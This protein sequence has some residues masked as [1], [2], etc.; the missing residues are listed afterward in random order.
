MNKVLY[1]QDLFYI[2]KVICSELI[3]M[4]HDDPLTGHFKIEKEWELIAKKYN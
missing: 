2:L 1:Y 3:N 4:Y